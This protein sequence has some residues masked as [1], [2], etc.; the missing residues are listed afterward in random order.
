M[1]QKGI[2]DYTIELDGVNALVKITINQ[3][4]A[5]I[6]SM[7]IDLSERTD[8]RFQWFFAFAERIVYHPKDHATRGSSHNDCTLM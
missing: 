1:L 2:K 3:K 7:L 4:T 5:D 6:S 8:N